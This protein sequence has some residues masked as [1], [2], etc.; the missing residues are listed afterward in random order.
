MRMIRYLYRESKWRLLLAAITSTIGGLA[1][2]TLVSLIS[3]AM[4]ATSVVPMLVWQFFGCCLLIL[5]AK[6][7]SELTLLRLMQNAVL[8]MR[9]TI[10]HKLLATPHKKLQEVGKAGLQAIVTRDVEAFI[11]AFQALPMV[12]SNAII[13]VACMGY[14][15]WLSWQMF[16]CLGVFLVVGVVGY[17]AAE[18]RPL[19]QL[20]RIREKLNV[21]FQDFRNLIEGSKE[22]QLNRQRGRL[23]VEQIITEGSTEYRNSFVSAMSGYTWITNVA[24][25]LFYVVLGLLLFAVPAVVPQT[26]DTL[27][28]VT[29][30]LL[31]MIRPITEMT[32]TLPMVRQSMIALSRIEQLSDKLDFDGLE[33]LPGKPFGEGKPFEL[34]LRGV[35]HHYPS[36]TDDSQFMLGPLNLIIKEG[37]IMFIVGGNGSGKTTLGMMLLGFYP[38]E[39]GE[40]LMNGVPVTDENMGNFRQYFSAVFADFHLFQQLLGTDRKELSEQARVYLDMLGMG[41]KVKIDDGKFSTIDLS[42]GQR[43]R[44]ALVSSYLDDRP[45]YLFD[46]WAADQDPVFKR[47]FYTK[48]LPDLKRRGKTVILITHDDAYFGC[49]DRIIKLE[50]G[51]LK[52]F[53]RHPEDEEPLGDDGFPI[54]AAPAAV[55]V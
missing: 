50:D 19:R 11:M 45:I 32:A 48:L 30:V 12:F 31:F 14:L 10:S 49:A 16:L 3:E 1:G 22:L 39:K 21:L 42:T 44:L 27:I 38:P 51:H 28:K 35:C 26:S 37:E 53:H 47:V 13:I 17:H 25:I 5:A 55:A 33:C 36:A 46:E 20:I 23:F 40:L 7:T 2:A 8:R 34:E 18:R 41:Q 43:K 9:I 24:G 54:P 15:A 4:T 29:M 52:P 6:T